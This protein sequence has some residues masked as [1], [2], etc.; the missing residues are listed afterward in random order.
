ME[1][2]VVGLGFD[3]LYGCSLDGEKK[4]VTNEDNYSSLKEENS[5]ESI[6]QISYTLQS[7]DRS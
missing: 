6:S 1:V 2:R 3:G 7:G 4:V 5:L